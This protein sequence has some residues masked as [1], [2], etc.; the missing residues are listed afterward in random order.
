MTLQAWQRLLSSCSTVLLTQITGLEVSILSMDVNLHKVIPILPAIGS[1]F[2]S[3][4][5]RVADLH[6]QDDLWPLC[7]AQGEVQG[8]MAAEQVP[9]LHYSWDYVVFKV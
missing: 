5:D 9:V 8:H 2:F 3:R 6:A 1:I 7:C 4:H